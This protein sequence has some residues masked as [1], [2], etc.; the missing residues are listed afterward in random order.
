LRALYAICI[1]MAG[2][3]AMP[4]NA[5]ANLYITQAATVGVPTGVVSE[6]NA[7]TGRLV[8]A[9]F[10]TWLNNPD[11]IAFFHGRT[12]FGRLFVANAI[13]GTV[14]KYNAATGE[15]IKANFITGLNQAQ[16]IAV[17]Q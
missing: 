15:V 11:S 16:G 2:L 14:G 12:V 3:W 13:G 4:G 8:H 6:Y 1:V 7:F 9:Q 10:I 17:T 5:R